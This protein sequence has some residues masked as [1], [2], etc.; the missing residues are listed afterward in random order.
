[1]LLVYSSCRR[2]LLQERFARLCRSMFYASVVVGP[3]CSSPRVV[4]PQKGTYYTT[5]GTTRTS[6]LVVSGCQSSCVSSTFCMTKKQESVC[7]KI[8]D[9]RSIYLRSL[10]HIENDDSKNTEVPKTSECGYLL[11]RHDSFST[12]STRSIRDLS[13]SP[14]QLST[15]SISITPSQRLLL[16]ILLT[17]ASCADDL[18]MPLLFCL[19]HCVEP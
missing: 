12:H 13:L 19:T 2:L 17:R 4:V 14:P 6:W 18:Y 3:V 11:V 7:S 8:L 5:R 1:M 10:Y 15:P 9:L 16:P